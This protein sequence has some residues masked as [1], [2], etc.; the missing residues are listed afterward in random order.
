M[1]DVLGYFSWASLMGGALFC[2]I[3]AIGVLRFP[4]FYTRT[5]AA[6]ITD[7]MGAGLVILG[8]IFQ[9]VAMMVAGTAGSWIILVKLIMVGLFILLTAPTSGHALVKA[10]YAHGLAWKNTEVDNELSS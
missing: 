8:L 1:I 9:A 6:S 5:H 3:G 7:T 4:D 2:I 10:A